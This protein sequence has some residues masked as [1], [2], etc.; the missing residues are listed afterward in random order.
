MKDLKTAKIILAPATEADLKFVEN[1]YISTRIDEFAMI[2]WDEEQLRQFLAMQ[3]NIQK[4]AYSHQFPDAENLIICL[5]KEKIGRLIVNRNTNELRLVDISLLPQFQNLGVGTKIIKDL[6]NEAKEKKLPLTLT[7]AR[8][9][10]AAF[11]LYQKL[12]FQITGEDEMYISMVS[13]KI[14]NL[15]E[16]NV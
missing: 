9:N 10:P 11:R 16:I 2:G 14:K 4:Q 6:L 12:G 7:V 15:G 13:R 3:N 5:E 1:V 8:N